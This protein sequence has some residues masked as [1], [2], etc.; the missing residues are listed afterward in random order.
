MSDQSI[1]QFI[2]QEF[3]NQKSPNQDAFL[4]E[5]IGVLHGLGRIDM[6][7]VG[8]VLHGIEI[9]SERDSLARLPDQVRIFGSVMD[10]M[11]LFVAFRHADRALKMVPS[12]WGVNLVD[13]DPEG[14]VS[15]YPARSP[16]LN[17]TVSPLALAKL[18]WKVEALDLI[19]QVGVDP[20]PYQSKTR[21]SI[22]QLVCEVATLPQI[23]NHVRACFS[24]RKSR[25]SAEVQKLDDG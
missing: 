3:L 15:M 20:K 22:Q 14:V 25:Q 4:L 24:C 12:W 1:R 7:M 18:L 11:T 19:K 16:T 5:E 2:R 13:L 8:K 6:L 10:L 21:F 17:L 9:K 23:Q